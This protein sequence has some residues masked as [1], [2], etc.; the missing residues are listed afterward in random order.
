[1]TAPAITYL[2]HST[3][4][5]E[6]DGMRLL[7]D[8]LLRNWITF[9]RRTRPA[10]DP[11]MVQNIDAVL[12]SHLHYDHLDIA[13]LRILGEKMKLI[14]PR[15]SEPILRKHGFS[16][17]QE[18]RIGETVQIGGLTVKTVMA[19]HGG[20]RRPLGPAS[21]CIGFVVGG[22]ASVYF[23]GDTRAFPEMAELANDN[24]D[25]ALMPV[26]GWGTD[27]GRM[28]MGPRE[29]A[30]A[31]ELLRP[32]LAVPI[33]WGTFIP[34]WLSWMQPGFHYLPPLLFAEYAGKI[35][36]SVEVHILQPGESL[37]LADSGVP[38]VKPRRSARV[39]HTN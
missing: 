31:L 30:E 17:A 8:P 19:D 21:D 29:A 9:L 15:G 1:M 11:A 7:T 37:S 4:L 6:M 35:T 36:S 18:V 32:R 26:W 20:R 23:P 2:G 27:R 10:I 33:H 24:L 38:N 28:H 12:I 14:I 34:F 39:D 5:I 13:S 3:I 22:S 16:N 25:L